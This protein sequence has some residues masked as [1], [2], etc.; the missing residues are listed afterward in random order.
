MGLTT[1]VY[2]T[3]CVKLQFQDILVI[4]LEFDLFECLE[5]PVEEKK[6]LIFWI[7]WHHDQKGNNS[8]KNVVDLTV[9]L[10]LGLSDFSYAVFDQRSS[11]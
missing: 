5:Q 10:K 1:E 6:V 11:L 8:K 9:I 4:G 3:L 7:I 2:Y